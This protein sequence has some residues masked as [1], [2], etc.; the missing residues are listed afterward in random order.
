MSR[1]LV[2]ED[3]PHILRVICLWL[4]RQGHEVTEARNGLEGLERYEQC[5]PHVV[6]TDVNMPGLDG[7]GLLAR[8]KQVRWRTRGVIVLT[9]RWDH[10]QIAS[11]LDGHDVQVVPKPFSPTRLADLIAGIA[12]RD[13]EQTATP[14]ETGAS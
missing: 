14:S 13:D 5:L 6:V 4:R 11:E 1:V 10:R 2:V 3:D 12:E 9:N 7:L 8:I